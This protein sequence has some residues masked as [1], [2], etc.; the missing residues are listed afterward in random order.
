MPRDK[1][2]PAN[3]GSL[4]HGRLL[5][6]QN[7]DRGACAADGTTQPHPTR[8]AVLKIR[9]RLKNVVAVKTSPR[10]KSKVFLLR[11]PAVQMA[12]AAAAAVST[13]QRRRTPFVVLRE[14]ARADKSELRESWANITRQSA[15]RSVTFIKELPK[16][17][18]HKVRNT[19]CAREK[20]NSSAQKIDPQP[21]SRRR[22]FRHSINNRERRRRDRKR[23]R[24]R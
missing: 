7:S 23:D 19:S 20:C 21:V 11:H 17:Q 5:Q 12:I 10:S 13:G 24:S 14:G 6:R 9:D 18:N 8:I 15:R 2:Y 1:E 22:E 3:R 4:D 16:T